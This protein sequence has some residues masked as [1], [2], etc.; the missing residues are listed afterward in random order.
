MLAFPNSYSTKR[1][2]PP[3]TNAI[4]R[5]KRDFQKKTGGNPRT[6]TSLNPILLVRLDTFQRAKCKQKKE[7]SFVVK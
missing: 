7:G 2:L 1:E 5:E 3:N 6:F 4:K